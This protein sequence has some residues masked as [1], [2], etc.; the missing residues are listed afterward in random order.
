M[1]KYL[2][3]LPIILIPLALVLFTGCPKDDDGVVAKPTITVH[4]AVLEGANF[5]LDWTDNTEDG[6]EVFFLYA[7]GL[8]NFVDSTYNL[9]Y[10]FDATDRASIVS[11]TALVGDDESG[12]AEHDLSLTTTSSLNVWSTADPD[13]GHPSFVKFT[14]GTATAVSANHADDAT[15]YINND[16]EFESIK[17]W[18]GVTTTV[19]PAFAD[20]STPFDFAPGTGN[21]TRPWPTSGSMSIGAT[22]Y[23]WIDYPTLGSMGDEDS[24]AKIYVV[25]IVGNKVTLNIFYQ[26]EAGLRWLV[27]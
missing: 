18:S 2:Y 8:N 3:I 25:D 1:K 17:Y 11:V 19:D 10:T 21:Y 16:I 5:K 22:Y 4:T 27:D 13:T 23:I 7:G 12:E 24:F 26:G 20:A 15:F 6:S 14:N 9:A